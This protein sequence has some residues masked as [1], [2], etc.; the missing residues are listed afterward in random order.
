MSPFYN[1]I[2]YNLQSKQGCNKRWARKNLAIKTPNGGNPVKKKSTT[3]SD[4][5]N[6]NNHPPSMSVTNSGTSQLG[7]RPAQKEGCW[8]HN[9]N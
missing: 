1:S 9:P 7:A 8:S 3:V 5:D 4:N 6:Q 2:D